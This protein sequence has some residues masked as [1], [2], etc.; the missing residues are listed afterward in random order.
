MCIF[1]WHESSSVYCEYF[2]VLRSWWAPL[3]GSSPPRPVQDQF[4]TQDF[5]GWL[6]VAGSS[7]PAAS[8][9]VGVNIKNQL[10]HNLV[11][12]RNILCRAIFC[13]SHSDLRIAICYLRIALLWHLSR[14]RVVSRGGRD[15]VNR[16]PQLAWLEKRQCLHNIN[17][18]INWT[19]AFC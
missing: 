1:T 13:V 7:H 5:F 8:G 9:D 3:E 17:C 16:D 11:L 2:L 15:K 6:S 19:F 4:W 10:R 18:N 14:G 12:T